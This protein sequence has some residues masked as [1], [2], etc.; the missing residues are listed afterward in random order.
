MRERNRQGWLRVGVPLAG[1]LL[2][3]SAHAEDRK[4]RSDI[5]YHVYGHAAATLQGKIHLLGGCHTDDWQKPSATHQAYDPIIDKWETKADLPLASAWGMPAV[6]N[7]KIYLFGGGCY[8][9]GQGM[10]STD[11]AWVYD[12][13]ADKWSGIRKL[14]EPRMNGFA[15]RGGRVHLYCSWLQPAGRRG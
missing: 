14:P 9:P 6:H 13:A 10:T 7:E 4:V 2:V 1:A 8:K 15:A 12:L 11:G 5:P 3:A